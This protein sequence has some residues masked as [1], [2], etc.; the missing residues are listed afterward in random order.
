MKALQISFSGG[1]TSA[2]MAYLLLLEPAN[3]NRQVIITFANTGQEDNRTLDFVH[4][5]DQRLFGKRVVWLEAEVHGSA[6]QGTTHR[7]VTYETAS[8]ITDETGPFERVIKKYG[9]PNRA[10]PNC[11]R[12]LKIRPMDSY[13]RSLGLAKKDYET[14]IGIRADEIDRIPT[15]RGNF[16]YPLA[17]MEIRKNDVLDFW[18]KMPFDL[19]LPE[20]FG[21]CVWCWK[22]SKRKLLTLVRQRPE[23]FEFPKKMEQLYP[24][25]GAGDGPRVFFRGH[26][27]VD[28]LFRQAAEPFSIFSDR[29]RPEFDPALDVAGACSESCEVYPEGTL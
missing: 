21:N 2:L 27:T 16:I 10:F 1:R 5:C 18:A 11:T 9:I 26:E 22:K 12:E 8:R 24:N 20:H 13:L 25:A 14:A 4:E 29:A 17:D 19:E 6:G 28:D 7:V 23:V 3:R 15:N